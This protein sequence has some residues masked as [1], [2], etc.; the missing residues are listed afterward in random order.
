[1]GIYAS[2]FYNRFD[3][4][5]H[6]LHYPQKPLVSTKTMKFIRFKELPAGINAIVAIM[7]YGGYNQ[8][9]SVLINKGAID[10]GLFRSSFFRTY[11]DQEKEIVRVGGLMEK[12]EIPD[13]TETKGIQ[14]GNYGK[15]AKDGL[16]EPGSRVI[17]ND[18]II[19][20]TTPLATN[21]H[22][23]NRNKHGSN[24]KKRDVST[25]MR[26]NEIGVVDRVLLTSN[27]DGFKCTKVKIR[28]IR[29]P[30]IG[31]KV[32]CFSPD[33]EIL[34]MSGWIPVEK[35]TKDYKVAT[36]VDE[37]KL[38]YDYPT[39]I[40]EYDF[41][42]NMYE[43][44]SN[45]VSLKVTPNHRMWVATRTSGFK[46]EKAEEI[47]GKRRKYLKNCEDYLIDEHANDFP[48]EFVG[49]NFVIRNDEG[50]ITF[51]FPINDWLIMFGI[52]IAEGYVYYNQDLRLYYVE[53]CTNKKRVRDALDKIGLKFSKY[54]KKNWDK[55]FTSY[56]INSKDLAKYFDSL[57]I[58]GSVNK[59]LPNWVWYLTRDECRILIHGMMLGDG[60]IMKNGTRL[61]DTSSVKLRDSF[62]K[63]CIHAGYSANYCLK[64]AAG[65][66]SI[67]KATDNR[68]EEIITSNYDA[69]RLTI[70]EKQNT[71]LVN[72]EKQLDKWEEYKGKVYCCTVPS[73]IIYVRRNGKGVWCGQS[74]HGQ[75]GTLGMVYNQEDMPF[76]E[77]GIVPD[78]IINPHA[79]PSRMTIGHLIECLL[80]KVS[81]LAGREGDSTPFTGLQ[82]SEIAEALEQ[83]GFAGDGTEVLYNGDSGEPLPARIFIGPTYYQRLKH[84]VKDKR[85]S[86][87]SGP[88]TKLT[89]QPLEGR[90]KEGGLRFGEMERD[91]LISH[92]T[93]N[94]LKD[95]LFF[96]SDPYR[97][98]VCKLCGTICQSDLDR[99]RF[100]CKCVKGGN[101]TEIAQVYIPYACKLFFQELMAMSIAPR[102]T[103]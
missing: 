69:W 29:I 59:D 22:E 84:M 57:N 49:N 82:V 38:K 42:G 18:V 83:Y 85:H 55:E 75:K 64:Y 62:Q 13:R 88:V 8:E 3:T 65:K 76:T 94:M 40:M 45:Q 70:V 48:G 2:N 63:L 72:E 74:R 43:I 79:I 16:I 92:G 66:Q 99:Q 101:T 53:W 103:F 9:D 97:V 102:I 14:H 5:A 87:S 32:A 11:V 77:D 86:R 20:K 95:R 15:L 41:D 93:A 1:M 47:Y 6:V 81:V 19:G 10:R 90:S 100:L 91:A 78:I 46:I 60:H 51:E 23:I 54:Y 61:Y 24:F 98:H 31:D 73:G 37:K 35:L 68:P 67:I 36:L 25:S 34:T 26:P 21:K 4:L 71:P 12:F 17:E 30:E 96:N 89:R 33:H 28:S 58:T 56:R 27:S 52:W 44:N 7:T 50:E 39:E 80:G